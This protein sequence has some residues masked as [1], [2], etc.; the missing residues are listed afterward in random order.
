[1]GRAALD[2]QAAGPP[3]PVSRLAA[4]PDAARSNPTTNRLPTAEEAV[5]IPPPRPKRKPQRPYPRKDS[6]S[7]TATTVAAAPASLGTV[8]MPPLPPHHALLGPADLGLPSGLP[9]LGGAMHA[10]ALHQQRAMLGGPDGSEHAFPCGDELAAG[11]MLSS[12]TGGAGANEDDGGPNGVSDA[13]VAAVT[14]AASAAAAAAAAAVVS[15]AGSRVQ[16]YL[17]AH[18][19]SGFPFFGVAPGLMGA[20]SALGGG[21]AGGLP[22]PPPLA[23]MFPMAPPMVPSAAFDP[24]A[25]HH[26]AAAAAADATFPLAAAQP[27]AAE[28]MDGSDGSDSEGGAAAAGARARRGGSDGDSACSRE[29]DTAAAAQAAAAEQAAAQLRTLMAVSGGA[30]AAASGGAPL[31]PAGAPGQWG[32]DSLLQQWPLFNPSFYGLLGGELSSVD[33]TTCLSYL[34]PTPATACALHPH[35]TIHPTLPTPG[36][37]SNAAT[38]AAATAAAA[39]AAAAAG[40][41]PIAAAALALGAHRP[42]VSGRSGNSGS[43]GRPG[44]KRSHDR[45]AGALERGPSP[46]KVR[47]PYP[48][49]FGRH[50]YLAPPTL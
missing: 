5:N 42:K 1:L 19:P 16:A 30:G 49:V 20:M 12:P 38:A 24:M 26:L 7:L 29:A 39:A 50:S 13:T 2:A 9:L 6:D 28:P 35:P 41:P 47:G 22:A 36:L 48:S 11:M 27:P 23:G 45:V 44:S 21:A 3:A 17:A 34:P 43:S 32:W 10:H 31:A 33:G 14:A 37:P 40:L 8:C 18:P 25:L 4:P 46:K 15:A